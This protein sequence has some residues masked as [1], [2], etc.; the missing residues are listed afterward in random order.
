MFANN[1]CWN[2][3]AN[4]L[5]ID[6]GASG[7]LAFYDANEDDI[8]LMPFPKARTDFAEIMAG[9]SRR[10]DA[11]YVYVE[12]V[13]KFIA[14]DKAS[15]SAIATLHQNFGYILGVLDAYDFPICLVKPKV[16][17]ESVDAGIK[18]AY[19]PRWKAHLKDLAARTF[20]QC[21]RAITLKTADAVLILT[22]A[23]LQNHFSFAEMPYI[24]FAKPGRLKSPQD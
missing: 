15:A 21:E 20:P 10:D 8:S 5:A 1:H 22:H 6:P 23:L 11:V 19:G 17:Q 3:C 4:I 9:L 12:E 14:G 7:G 24:A 13:P 18:K 2:R 16:W